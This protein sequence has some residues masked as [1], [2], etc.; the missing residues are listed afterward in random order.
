MLLNSRMPVHLQ[1]LYSGSGVICHHVTKLCT[2]TLFCQA[3]RM[4]TWP[5]F[6]QQSI[7]Q[8]CCPQCYVDDTKLRSSFTFHEERGV[9]D[10]MMLLKI[11]NWC[12]NNQL[13]LN[14]EKVKLI[15]FGSRQNIAKV[16]D[17]FNLSLFRKDLVP[18]TTIAKD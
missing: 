6:V 11:W 16:N 17:D 18:A 12:F 13:L 1:L 15:I 7:P 8:Y 9:R 10:K 5:T 4:Y 14:P 3:L 2:S